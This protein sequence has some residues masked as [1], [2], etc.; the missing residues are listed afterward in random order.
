MA[1]TF[2]ALIS[3]LYNK[4]EPVYVGKVGTGFTHETLEELFAA[5]QLLKTEKEPFETG[6]H[7]EIRWLKPK[8]VCEIYYQVVTSDRRLRMPRFRVLRKDKSPSECT[9]NQLFPGML[10]EYIS[11]RNFNATAEPDGKLKED[12]ARIFAFIKRLTRTKKFGLEASVL[13]SLIR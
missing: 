11:K 12:K 8:L 6:L 13:N 2:G 1:K 3:G 7:E 5:F 9:L 10:T 4:G